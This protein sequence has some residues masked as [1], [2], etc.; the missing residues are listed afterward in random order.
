MCE[1]A[2]ANNER[3]VEGLRHRMF[4]A[5]TTSPSEMYVVLTTNKSERKDSSAAVDRSSK[6]HQFLL[7]PPKNS[8]INASI[9][10]LFPSTLLYP[11]PRLLSLF[12]YT[13]LPFS[14]LISCLLRPSFFM[15]ICYQNPHTPLFIKNNSTQEPPTA[16]LQI[17][18]STSIANCKPSATKSPKTSFLDISRNFYACSTAL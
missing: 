14:P 5:F 9:P 16:R 4:F 17:P 15:C 2:R 12:P 10:L 6:L 7:F 18:R 8:V 11:T 13:S 3:G 1:D